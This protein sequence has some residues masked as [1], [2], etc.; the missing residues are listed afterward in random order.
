MGEDFNIGGISVSNNEPASR[1]EAHIGGKVAILDYRRSIGE[2]VFT[3]TKVPR[4]LEGRGVGSK[5]VRAG[6]EFA[7][8]QRLTVVPQCPFVAWFI[9]ENPEFAGLARHQSRHQ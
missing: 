7:R 8:E 5:L 4:E 1:F 2:I 9:G 6:L 3:H